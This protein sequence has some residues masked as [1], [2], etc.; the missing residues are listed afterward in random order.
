MVK[1]FGR[2]R[3]QAFLEYWRCLD[4][5]GAMHIEMLP[6]KPQAVQVHM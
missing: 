6:L 3:S 2:W 4:Y 5:L 1:K